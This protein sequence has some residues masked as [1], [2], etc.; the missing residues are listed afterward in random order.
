MTWLEKLM[1]PDLRLFAGYSSS[2]SDAGGFVPA[3][4]IDANENPW[5]PFGP[6]AAQ[7]PL[8]R[9]PDPQPLELRQRLGALWGVEADKILLGRGSDEGIDVLMR[10][11]CRQGVDQ[12]LICPPTFGMYKVY[13]FVQGAGVLEVPLQKD[14]QLD[15][16]N[17]LKACSP[18]TKL[19]FIP[20]PNAPMG[21]RMNKDDILNLAKARAEKNLVVVDEAYVE[22]T[23]A[24]E[25]MLPELKNHSNLVILRTLSK[26]HSLAGERVGAVI[27]A[28]EL[29]G[30]MRKIMAPYPLAQS[31]IRA[32]LDAL[33]PNGLV[34]GRL[35]IRQLASERERMARLLAGSPF[36]VSIFPSVTN[37]LLVQTRDSKAFMAR[38]RQFGILARERHGDMSHT[39][40]LTVSTPEENDL[41]LKALDVELPEQK[42]SRSPRSHSLRR[43]TKETAID[44]TVDLDAPEFLAVETGIGFFDHM[45]AQIASHGGFG[46][47]LH[48]KGDLNVDQHHTIEDCALALGEALK[49]ALGGKRGIARFG[50]NAPLDEAL[51]QVTIDLSGRP[52]AVFTGAFPVPDIGGMSSEMVPHFF[53]SLASSLDA[54]IHVT[55]QGGNAH[56]MAEACFKAAGRALRQAFQREG[57]ALPSTK[58]VL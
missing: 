9:Y 5:P 4:E 54:A 57:S 17:V 44:V 40:R 10:L 28:P 52:C 12:V 55:V 21:H 18:E 35:R 6:M 11:F 23:D 2:H 45:L 29:I 38:L 43:T 14:G 16:P 39:V 32:A 53:Q 30:A 19:I 41:V 48:C 34:Q 24:P 15:V 13:A 50:F 42:I 56:H 58:G 7:S 36:V 3:I 25:G 27:A 31:S 22:F 1:R 8:N 33:S 46:L 51:A 37:F 47:E 49:N 26:A 20:S